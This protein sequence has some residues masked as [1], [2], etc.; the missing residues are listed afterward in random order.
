MT[1]NRRMS[2]DPF[3]GGT[4]NRIKD[5]RAFLSYLRDGPISRSAVKDWIISNTGARSRDAVDPNISFLAAIELIEIDDDQV[6]LSRRGTQYLDDSEPEVLY[7]ALQSNVKG[8]NTILRELE[9]NPMTDADI[10]DLLVKSFPETEMTTA[11]GAAHHREWLQAL[12][13][14][15]RS[16]GTN[17]LTSAGQDL[18]TKTN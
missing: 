15:K 13:Y 16:E 8:F 1:D 6:S 4:T 17:T 2:T 9:Q 14:I 12:G 7:Q 3:Y 11:R 5:L 18:M 10:R